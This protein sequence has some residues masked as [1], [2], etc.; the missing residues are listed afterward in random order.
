MVA[1]QGL[2]VAQSR[3]R[4]SLMNGEGV[5][6]NVTEAAQYYKMTA[7]QSHTQAQ[8]G[9]PRCLSRPSWPIAPSFQRASGGT[10][11]LSFPFSSVMCGT[12]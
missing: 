11:K 7:D 12:T 2:A 8:Q 10:S 6:K 5:R 1:A 3:Y 4:F 9:C